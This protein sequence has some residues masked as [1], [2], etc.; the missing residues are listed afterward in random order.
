MERALDFLLF[1]SDAMV[2]L[3]IFLIVGCGLAAR[4][5]VYDNFVKGA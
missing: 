2:P 4:I 5:Q 3:L 1:L